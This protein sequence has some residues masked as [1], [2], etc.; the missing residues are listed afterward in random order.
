MSLS[1]RTERNYRSE[2]RRLKRVMPY[3]TPEDQARCQ[4]QM[5]KLAD[6]LGIELDSPVL[7]RGP[8]R[9]S[10][11]FEVPT[12]ATEAERE[13]AERLKKER[14][15][16][17]YSEETLNRKARTR[18]AQ[19]DKPPITPEDV[20][21]MNERNVEFKRQQELA[22]KMKAVDDANN[23]AV[24]A[25]R[26]L[27]QAQADLEEEMMKKKDKEKIVQENREHVDLVKLA[28]D[29]E[30]GETEEIRETARLQLKIW[31]KEGGG[32]TQA[33]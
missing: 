12:Y 33:G 32:Q 1:V 17:D 16:L 20:A 25:E 15:A 18:A 7:S 22:L 30:F 3:L 5:E 23:E 9:P 27:K 26:K 14:D 28:N 8:G 6:K 13:E 24:A 19:S 4:R 29:A 11:S 10:N 21:R 31:G 2:L